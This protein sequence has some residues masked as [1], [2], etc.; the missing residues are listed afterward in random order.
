MKKSIVSFDFTGK[1]AVVTGGSKGIG[2]AIAQEIIDGDGK[3]IICSRNKA[4]ILVAAQKLGSNAIGVQADVTESE[5]LAK[6]FATA[7]KEFGG[8]ID[9]L[10]AN[11]GSAQ[12]CPISED[13]YE[14]VLDTMLNVKLK[15][16]L[17]TVKG[18][19]PYLGNGS[20]V[21][22]ISS[23]AGRIGM[24]AHST[25]SA[26]NGGLISA[27]NALSVEF[28]PENIKVIGVAPGMV[29]TAIYDGFGETDAEVQAVKDSLNPKV[30]LGRWAT[31][32]EMGLAAV[33]LA[34]VPY[35]H[36]ETVD[37]DGNVV[38]YF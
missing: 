21:V 13:A 28:A 15:G 5:D 22:L 3:V 30:A 9:F 6:L 31:P 7:D 16:I 14:T 37:V 27:V 11:A 10:F 29:D 2:F 35:L 1:T 19:K 4:E 18:A 36:G 20:A 34:N 24:A 8:K 23:I 26:A 32:E 33:M 38:R 17:M 25:Y 12:F